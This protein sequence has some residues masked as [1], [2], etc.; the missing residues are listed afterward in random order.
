MIDFKHVV[1]PPCCWQVL[2]QTPPVVAHFLSHKVMLMLSK[3]RA[4]SHYEAEPLDK[5]GYIERWP[6][7]CSPGLSLGATFMMEAWRPKLREAGKM[8]V[9]LRWHWNFESTLTDS[10]ELCCLS[11]CRSQC[12]WS[13]WKSVRRSGFH[14]DKIVFTNVPMFP[15]KPKSL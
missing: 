10:H 14:H 12:L 5:P 2:Q 8:T 15:V 4:I 13:C 7:R 1:L 11:D 6:S 3:M 9:K